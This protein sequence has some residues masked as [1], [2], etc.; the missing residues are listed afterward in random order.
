MYG[1]FISSLYLFSNFNHHRQHIHEKC[2]MDVSRQPLLVFEEMIDDK[3]ITGKLQGLQDNHPL[4]KKRLPYIKQV[5][6]IQP[7]YMQI[8]IAKRLNQVGNSIDGWNLDYD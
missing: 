3:T 1:L 4:S 2:N 5:H 8:Y 6:I 7:S